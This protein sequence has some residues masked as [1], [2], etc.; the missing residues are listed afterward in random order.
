[1][2][3]KEAT[4]RKNSSDQPIGSLMDA[5]GAVGAVAVEEERSESPPVPAISA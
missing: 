5:V 2:M 4:E 3:K 1:M